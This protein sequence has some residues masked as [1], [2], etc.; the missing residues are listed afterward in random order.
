ME[1]GNAR[2]LDT[3]ETAHLGDEGWYAGQAPGI[4]IKGGNVEQ[5][6]ERAIN[7]WTQNFP[8]EVVVFERLMEEMRKDERDDHYMTR[9]RN[10]RHAA[11]IPGR[12][13]HRVGLELGCADWILDES[14]RQRFF[15]RFRG[16]LLNPKKAEVRRDD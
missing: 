15:T 11:E 16:G 2:F 6:F 10:Y 5:A 8:S 13:Y 4:S 12:L 1:G 9:H 3:P 14:V 7:W